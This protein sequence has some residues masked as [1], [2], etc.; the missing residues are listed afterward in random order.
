[1]IGHYKLLIVDDSNFIRLTLKKCLQSNKNA[2]IQVTE[3]HDGQHALEILSADSFD[4]IITDLEMPNLNGLGLIAELRKSAKYDEVPIIFL[5][6]VDTSDKKVSAFECG[7]TDYLIKPFIAEELIARIFAHLERKFMMEAVRKKAKVAENLTVFYRRLRSINL[8]NLEHTLI[9]LLINHLRV[10]SVALWEFDQSKEVLQ[11]KI[12]SDKLGTEL[13]PQTDNESPMW[14]AFEEK[15]PV[16]LENLE[17]AAVENLGFNLQAY[18]GGAITVIPLA[19]DDKRFGI[20]NL[21]NFPATFFSDYELTHLEALQH[22]ISN[23]FENAFSYKIIKE[24]QEQTKAELKQAKDT[25]LAVLPQ[26]IPKLPYM[27]IVT[28]YSAMEEIGGDLYDILELSEDK[29]GILV[30]DVT[31]HGIPAALISCMSSSLFKATAASDILPKDVLTY[32]NDQLETRMPDGKFVT[33]FY[34]TYDAARETLFY[35]IAG[36]PP[37][38]VVRE[39]TGEIF[40]LQENTGV[41]L[42]VFSGDIASYDDASMKLQ[43]G[44]RVFF[45][46]DGIVEISDPQEEMFGN[47]RLKEFLL[48]NSKTP[49]E[50]VLDELYSHVLQATSHQE[51]DDDITLVAF[52][53][54]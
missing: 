36:H 14:K 17:G 46:T 2:P 41:P 3:A 53:I 40:P 39:A 32:I 13:P 50:N 33:A 38:Y 10:G 4:L 49:I 23:S 20:L 21:A 45:Y 28:K 30:A 7:A 47:A 48:A 19:I 27:K 16:F 52:E 34:S 29:V 15:Q 37:G 5:T 12:S 43:K 42:G 44:D 35:S 11:L 9:F 6:S 25:Q 31:G 8:E 18:S 54:T 22:Y 1:M 51:Y 26:K 24:K